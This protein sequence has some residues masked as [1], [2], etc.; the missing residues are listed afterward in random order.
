MYWI[1]SE[2]W[3]RILSKIKCYEDFS[4]RHSL[5]AITKNIYI[6]QSLVILLTS[7]GKIQGLNCL[8]TTKETTWPI[9]WICALQ[10]RRKAQVMSV[11]KKKKVS[12]LFPGLYWLC[13]TLLSAWLV[14]MRRARLSGTNWW[15]G[16]CG[17][18]KQLST[19]TF[20]LVIY[21]SFTFQKWPK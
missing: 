12:P 11:K 20:C 16:P 3:C 1:I 4:A 2:Q 10:P 21:L 14:K 17:V 5:Q 13:Q 19:M 7:S 6:S 8:G 18:F 9:T 15:K